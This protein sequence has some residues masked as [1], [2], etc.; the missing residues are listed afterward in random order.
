[1]IKKYNLKIKDGYCLVCHRPKGNGYLDFSKE[2]Q[3]IITDYGFSSVPE[4]FYDLCY[5]CAIRCL[6]WKGIRILSQPYDNYNY[7]HPNNGPLKEIDFINWLADQ[8]EIF[9]KRIT[10]NE[11]PYRCHAYCGKY[12]EKHICPNYAVDILDDHPL[13]HQHKTIYLERELPKIY[14]GPYQESKTVKLAKLL[15]Q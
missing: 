15:I 5:Q 13:C 6:S 2:L 7:M 9:S 14:K 8:L 1:M 4:K 3:L 12:G 10:N 11:L